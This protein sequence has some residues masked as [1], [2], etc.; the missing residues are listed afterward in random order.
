MVLPSDVPIGPRSGTSTA[1]LACSGRNRLTGRAIRNP[2]ESTPPVCDGRR[3]SPSVAV[4]VPHDGASL[5]PTPRNHNENN[6]VIP[7]KTQ[8]RMRQNETCGEQRYWAGVGVILMTA[9]CDRPRR[10]VWSRPSPLLV[11]L[12]IGLRS[13]CI[14][15]LECPSSSS[16][17][18]CPNID[19][20]PIFPGTLA[21]R[22]AFPGSS[23]AML[24]GPD[25][26]KPKEWNQW[27]RWTPAADAKDARRSTSKSCPAV[28]TAHLR[29]AQTGRRSWSGRALL[30]RI[31]LHHTERKTGM[32]ETGDSPAVLHLHSNRSSLGWLALRLVVSSVGSTHASHG[33]CEAR[34]RITH[35]L[36]L[37]RAGSANQLSLISPPYRFRQARFVCAGSEPSQPHTPHTTHRTAAG[38]NASDQN[39][40]L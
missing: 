9:I 15:N 24:T 5:G 26:P 20:G 37:P 27:D 16:K 11:M 32:P 23:Q 4:T 29:M 25:R 6:T 21:T 10:P 3:M 19:G 14:W 7:C 22:R 39:Q 40:F 13:H 12:T 38:I 1:M 28:E 31:G 30:H 35:S 2:T 33:C 34:T 17:A 36:P 8:C 18:I